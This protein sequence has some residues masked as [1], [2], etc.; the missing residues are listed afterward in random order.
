MNAQHKAPVAVA[1]LTG[2]LGAGKTT[3]LNYIL[4][5]Q[6][7][8]K[9]AV[10]VNDI[11]EVNIDARLIAE[12]GKIISEDSGDVVPLSN[13]C[14]CCTLKAD[15][16][17]QLAQLADSGKFDYI[18]IEAS[19]IC[20]PLPIA[21]TIAMLNQGLERG[22]EPD[23]CRLD[24][25]ITVADTLRLA[26]E[27]DCGEKMLQEDIDEEDIE[28]LLIQQLEF[29]NTIIMN[30]ADMVSE[31]ERR[32]VRAVIRALAPEARII[33]TN[34]GKVDLKDILG[35]QL[36]DFEKAVTSAGW[37][38]ALENPEEKEE[39]E[40][41]EYGIETFVYFRR[42]PFAH[43]KLR[44]LV[45][46]WP[47]NI[48]R[49]KGFLWFAEDPETAYIFEQAGSQME[50]TDDGLWVAA[51]DVETRKEI[52]AA[53]PELLSEWDDEYGDR[54]IRLVFIGQELDKQALTARLDECLG[55]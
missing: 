34:Y 37:I 19:G 38:E 45:N 51:E 16:M 33:E 3:L 5:E 21:Q 36:F 53:N 55:E 12:G 28:A 50:L 26:Q 9:V 52:L 6:H 42:R 39:G 46:S 35:T 1:L 44:D 25:I 43:D 32:R 18:L 15:L 23:L 40:A 47:R 48:I 10:I 49:C 22:D 11:G 20:E 8:Y 41:L 14:I 54:M 24:N 4:N 2:Y 17:Q 13:G 31:E 7:G 29:C 30:K 27:F